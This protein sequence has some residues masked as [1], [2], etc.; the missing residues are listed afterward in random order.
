[1]D[2]LINRIYGNKH[3]KKKI[4]ALA[5]ICIVGASSWTFFHEGFFYA[6]DFLHTAR[7]GEMTRMLLDGQFPPRWSAN[8]GYGY[9][10]PLFEFY[11][12][13]PYLVG[14]VLELIGISSILNL[15]MLYIL[16]T[17]ATAGG[18][19]FLGKKV[20][21]SMDGLFLAAAFTLAPYR[22]VNI[23]VRG[24]MSEIFGMMTY[25]WIL[26]AI[27]MIVQRKHRFGW[28][29][30]STST[31]ILLLSH[32]LSALIF[33]P[34]SFL[35]ALT[36]TY[37]RRKENT[38]F[39]KV[40][41]ELA[42]GYGL[43][44]LLS[45]FYSL[46][47]VFEKNYTRLDQEILGEYF[48]YRVHFLGIK[49]F[50]RENWGYGGSGYGENDGI[51]FFLG[52]GQI[53]SV[54]L[55]WLA[56]LWATIR[57]KNLPKFS[58][59][60]LSL[61]V[62]LTFSMFLAYSRSEFLWQI[63]T[64]LKYLQF[65]W[66]FL[67]AAAILLPLF[68]LSALSFLPSKIKAPLFFVLI[69]LMVGVNMRYFGPEEFLLSSEIGE[70]YY[71]DEK[72]IRNDL[73]AWLPD[74]IPISLDTEIGAAQSPVFGPT[75]GVEIIES[76]SVHTKVSLELDQ[77]ELLIFSRAD[78]PGWRVFLN[79]HETNKI[80]TGDGLVALR[81]PGGNSTAEVRLGRSSVRKVADSISI[82]ALAI[83]LILV[84]LEAREPRKL[85]AKNGA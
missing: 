16:V 7:I 74:Y 13:F 24:A 75:E 78:Y 64:P 9:G 38:N 21:G 30:L 84:T 69:L 40:I 12:P 31:A 29:L 34:F 61:F 18:C 45:A 81:A 41:L 28:L 72:R 19:Y 47:A 60:P 85:N 35:F 46:P 80:V 71:Q 10:M 48:N 27:V 50:F 25:P 63:L 6:H 56:L 58:L 59:W 8:F 20:W 26:L 66:R 55:G 3:L 52:Y 39:K 33:L 36:Y 42:L 37:Y 57:R 79:G 77:P 11:A 32:N 23:F 15:K 54:I 82:I 62:L 70:R 73:S 51:S 44:V 22:A 83:L 49:Q 17:I 14:A 67:S 4:V 76:D 68:S 53:A 5:I 2:K 1:M 65:P 43:G